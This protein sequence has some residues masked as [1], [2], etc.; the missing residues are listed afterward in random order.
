MILSEEIYFE[1]NL[2]GKKADVKNMV[3]FLKSGELED[4]F[5]IGSEYIVYDDD[6]SGADDTQETG[7]TFT[8]D[9]MGIEVEEFD[10]DAFLEIFCKA[11]TPLDVDGHIYDID[12]EE[13]S[14]VSRP[15]SGDYED[16][17]GEKRFNDELDEE[18]YAE[19]R[20]AEDD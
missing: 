15:G 7:F 13:Y 14:F 20:E 9:D 5:D 10:T 1:I 18:M 12:D 19:E 17:Q 4:F 6:F 11:A 8:N 2:H 16:A 3:K